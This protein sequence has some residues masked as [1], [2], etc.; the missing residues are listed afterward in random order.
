MVSKVKKPSA[1]IVYSV[2]M[3]QTLFFCLTY[4][5]PNGIICNYF[6]LLQISLWFLSCHSRWCTFVYYRNY[7][8]YNRLFECILYGMC[9][10]GWTPSGSEWLDY[11]NQKHKPDECPVSGVRLKRVHGMMRQW[12]NRRGKTSNHIFLYQ[13]KRF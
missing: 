6:T 11:F 7:W 4:T 10:I 2:M 1:K 12:R 9:W 8:K 3:W 13:T 5:F